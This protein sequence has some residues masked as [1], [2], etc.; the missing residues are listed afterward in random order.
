MADI[1][2]QVDE[3][4]AKVE[5]AH[6][7]ALKDQAKAKQ[8]FEPIDAV[9]DDVHESW[10]GSWAGY[11]AKLYYRDFARPDLRSQFSVEWGSLHGLPDGWT[12]RT[13]AE[14]AS[15]IESTSGVS[16]AELESMSAA[17]YDRAY[18]LYQDAQALVTPILESSGDH[19]KALLEELRD[20]QWGI[21]QA[22]Y[23]NRARPSQIASRD[24]EAAMQGMK[25]PPHVAFRARVV[26]EYSR[27]TA[28]VSALERAKLALKQARAALAVTA[29][30]SGRSPEP[31]SS[32]PA[33]RARSARPLKWLVALLIAAVAIETFILLRPLVV[34]WFDATFTQEFLTTPTRLGFSWSDV[35]ANTLAALVLLPFAWLVQ[36]AWGW[37]ATE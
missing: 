25:T 23:L 34:S 5:K 32:T 33:V 17:A 19:S 29:R 31:S 28:S 35:V 13:D 14:V 7:L 6:A 18:P 11:H 20:E 10:S 26:S 24:S 3:L 1:E 36:K 8:L 22:V 27:V 15:Y 4:L 30:T 2:K 16:V 37:L 21:A 9:V 12:D